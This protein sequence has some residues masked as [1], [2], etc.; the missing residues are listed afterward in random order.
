[1]DALQTLFDVAGGEALPLPEQLAALYGT[2]AFPRGDPRAGP[3]VIGNFVSTLDGVVSLNAPAQAGGGPIS[4]D[5]ATDLMVMGLLRACA[6]VVIEGAGTVRQAPES[7]LN[8]QDV[9][10][11]MAGAYAELRRRL[12]KPPMPTAVIVSGDGDL[13]VKLRIFASAEMPVLV[14]ARGAGAARLAARAFPGHVR[15]LA[16]GG[17]GPLSARDMIDAVAG[18]GGL[19]LIEGGPRL[20]TAF[21]AEKRLHELFLTMAPQIAGRDD[22][23][24]RPGFIA[25]QPFAPNDPRWGELLSVKRSAS[26]L[27]LRYAFPT[28]ERP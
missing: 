1:M 24:M 4:G 7:T 16:Q 27:F 19:L 11:P 10:P 12:N 25:G 20:M 8:A 5:N 23:I 9:Y 17:T 26:H 18:H 28:R 22:K 21:V 15:V 13:D 14:L 6:D 3:R 2:L